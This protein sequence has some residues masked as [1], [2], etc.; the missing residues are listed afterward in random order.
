M[1]K[2]ILSR[3][4]AMRAKYTALMLLTMIVLMVA[5]TGSVDKVSGQ[6]D[7]ASYTSGVHDPG[8][9]YAG[10]PD[11][12]T[13][14][15]DGFGPPLYNVLTVSSDDLVRMSPQVSRAR[16]QINEN[17]NRNAIKDF[18][19]NN[20]GAT[21]NDISKSLGINAGTVR[22]HLMILEINH[23]VALYKDGAKRIRYFANNGAYSKDQMMVISLLKREPTSRLL[24]ALTGNTGM[25]NAGI[26]V[27]SGLS[28]SDV[29]RYLKE[30]TAKGVVLKRAIG[31]EKYLYLINP[32]LE[33]YM[34]ANL[35]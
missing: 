25:S 21:S 35:Q 10:Q 17:E 28:Y 34:I 16:D 15:I 31:K 7:L 19:T 24:G 3:R 18:I 29:N 9:P 2:L 33:E 23:M 27:V 11:T 30:L 6:A 5:C 1:D 32:A 14:M 20:P 22:Y 8:T 12:R 13:G 26:T 4:I